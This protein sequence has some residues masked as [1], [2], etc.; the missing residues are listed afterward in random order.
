MKKIDLVGRV[1]NRLTV[2][3]QTISDGYSNTRWECLCV[4]GGVKT[5]AGSAL[6]GGKTGSCGCLADDFRTRRVK[7]K[8]CYKGPK[9]SGINT[10]FSKYKTHAKNRGHI[11]TLT[12]EYFESLLFNNCVYCSDPTTN[13]Q[14][15]WV[16]SFS[17]NGIDRI[18]NTL[19]YTNE[20]VVTCCGFCNKAKGTHDV[21]LFLEKI[22]KIHTTS[23]G[24]AL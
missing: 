7:F 14:T 22:S 13:T 9:V 15:S 8:T 1:F 12:R 17:Y 10:L 11:F 3:K 19:G 2:L 5:V 20:N 24:K 18:D 4:C 16:D 23:G 21:K 6:L